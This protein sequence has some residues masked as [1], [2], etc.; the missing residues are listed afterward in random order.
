MAEHLRDLIAQLQAYDLLDLAAGLGGLQLLPRNG[1]SLGRLDGRRRG[2]RPRSR[3]GRHVPCQVGQL[4]SRASDRSTA[5]SRGRSAPNLFVEPFTTPEDA[6][7]LLPGLED[8]ASYVLRRVAEA[9][10]LSDAED[11]RARARELLLAGL[12]LA[13]TV[14]QRAD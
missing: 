13:D 12:A 7:T 4:A 11:T 9:A 5:Q 14:C 3:A 8:D 2:L 6:F 1:R 10:E